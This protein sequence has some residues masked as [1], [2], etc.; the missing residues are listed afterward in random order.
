MD[1]VLTTYNIIGR[2]GQGPRTHAFL[3]GLEPGAP[4]GLL[5]GVKWERVIL[6]EAHQVRNPKTVSARGVY[7]LRSTYRWCLTG[8][9]IHNKMLDLYS[10][11]CFLKFTP[12]NNE[13]V[14]ACRSHT[15]T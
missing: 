11:L 9:P 12:F 6:D 8:T 15:P 1:V 3:E 14:T 13:Q 2:E 5:F 7:Q 4:Q 10:L